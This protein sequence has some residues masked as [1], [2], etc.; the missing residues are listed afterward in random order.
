MGRTPS[1]TKALLKQSQYGGKAS[2]IK[3]YN[4]KISSIYYTQF[5]INRVKVGTERQIKDSQKD[6]NKNNV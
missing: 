4:K 5:N 1:Q 6:K 3:V 2:R